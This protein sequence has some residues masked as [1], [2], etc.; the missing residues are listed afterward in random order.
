MR[1]EIVNKFITQLEVQLEEKDIHLKVSDGTK[2][3]CTNGTDDKV[4]R[5]WQN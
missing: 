5:T 2:W 1:H 3:L 4:E